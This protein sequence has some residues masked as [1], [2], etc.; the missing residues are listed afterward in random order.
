MRKTVYIWGSAEQYPRYRAWVESAGGRAVFG[1]ASQG[2]GA[3]WDALL[4]PGGG[5]LEPWRYGQGNAASRGLEPE[6]DEAEFQ[7]LQEFTAAGKPVLGVCRGLQAINVFFGGTLV[8]DIPGHGAWEDGDRVHGVRTAPSPLGA[9]CG[10]SL[11]V[12]SAH[13]QAADR[14]G[15]GLQA[16]QWAGDG[17]VEALCHRR[18]PVW[19]VQWHPER[20]RDRSLGRRLMGAFLEG[21]G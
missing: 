16:V 8:Q 20:L 17:V 1:D 5:D 14:L 9:L 18:L 13:H 15:G 10:G 21:R 7:L 3:L 19:A 6:R 2:P 4:L 12:N 11:A